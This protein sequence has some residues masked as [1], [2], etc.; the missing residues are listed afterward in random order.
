MQLVR[1]F[2]ALPSLLAAAALATAA[3]LPGTAAAAYPDKPVRLVVPFA[4]GGPSD[5]LGRAIGQKLS[6]SLGQPVIIENKPGAGTN[7]AADHVARAAPDGH[8][9]FLMMVGTQA[10]NEAMYSK[11]SYDTV[12]D[13]APVGLVASS[14]LML[15]AHPSVPAKH[16]KDVVRLAKAEPGRYN[17]ASSGAGTPLHLGGELLNKNTG[18]KLVHVPY[19]GANPALQDVLGG[20]V[21]FAMVGT[22]S[23]LAH[24]KGGKLTPIGVTSAQRTTLAPDVPTIA[25]TVPG[26]EV[27]LV[28]AIVAPANTPKDVVARL[29]SEINKALQ[30]PDLREKLLAQGFEV[31]TSTPE[32]LG[33]YIRNEIAKWAPIVKEAGVKA[34]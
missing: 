5:V 26:Y 33:T 30:E 28:Y 4:A 21:Q 19:K 17:F 16:L 12:R 23:V 32:Q 18:I 10:I 14:S 11:L 7:L 3:A 6:P 13:F 31:R 24:I 22:P 1:S 15:V 8:T 20:Q 25:E 34:E 2:K 27:E 29:N 9:L